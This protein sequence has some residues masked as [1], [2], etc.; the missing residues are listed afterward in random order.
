MIATVSLATETNEIL[1]I[2]PN[3][4]IKVVYGSLI[5]PVLVSFRDMDPS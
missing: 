3:T 1:I 2:H 4:K 5:K